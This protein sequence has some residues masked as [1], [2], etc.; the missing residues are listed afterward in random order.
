M[1]Y[2]LNESS[3]M[4]LELNTDFAQDFEPSGNVTKLTQHYTVAA[5]IFT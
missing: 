3:S 4:N 2:N 1:K 5:C